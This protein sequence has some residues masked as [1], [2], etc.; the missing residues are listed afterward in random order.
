MRFHHLRMTAFGPFPDEVAIDLDALGESGLFL[1]HGPTGAGKTSILDAI[2]FALFADVP[3]RRPRRG[4]RSDH[5][6]EG[7]APQ[8]V[9]E[10]TAGGTRYRITRSAE[11]VRPKLRGS[12]TTTVPAK[13]TLEQSVAGRWEALSARHDEVAE[14]IH[15][16]LGLGLDQF[17]KVVVLPQGEFAAFLRSSAEDRR[18]LLERLFDISA[19]ADVETWLADRRRTTAVAA[20]RATADLETTLARIDDVLAGTDPGATVGV[21]ATHDTAELS[22]HMSAVLHEARSAVTAT[23][24]AVDEA[25]L[26]E[27]E[28]TAEHAA[29]VRRTEARERAEMALRTLADLA[30]EEPGHLDRTDRVE[31]AVRAAALTGHLAAFHRATTALAVAEEG[32]AETITALRWPGLPHDGGGAGEALA[33]VRAADGAAHDLHT[34]QRRRDEAAER[35]AGYRGQQ[36]SEKVTLAEAAER[37]EA[38]EVTGQA[39]AADLSTALLIP[40]DPQP[41]EAELA[42]LE[43][44][45]EELRSLADDERSCVDLAD[46]A[47]AAQDAALGA[48]AH[49]LDLR[50]AQLAGYAAQLAQGL[51][52]GSPC[53][54]C[55]SAEHPQPATDEALV[56]PEDVEAAQVRADRLAEESRGL[57]LELAAARAT[58]EQRRAALGDLDEAAIAGQRAAAE[59]ALAA[60]RTQQ[61]HIADLR[62]RT[63]RHEAEVAT[64]DTALAQAT[65]A[66]ATVDALVAEAEREEE[67]ANTALGTARDAHASCPCLHH[68]DGAWTLAHH[69]GIAAELESIRGAHEEIDRSSRVLTA[70]R[71]DAAAAATS[72]GFDDLE[73]AARAQ[74]PTDELGE[75]Q[76]LIRD[77][78]DRRRAAQAVLSEP[79]VVAAR[80]VPADDLAALRDRAEAAR[81]AL[82][83]ATRAQSTAEQRLVGLSRLVPRAMSAARTRDEQDGLARRVRD[84]ADTVG[85]LG[86]DNTLRMRLTAFV[87]AARLETVVAFANERLSRLGSGRYRLEHSDERSGGG[88][89]G[90]GL[91]VEDQ[92]TGI[93]REAASLSGGETFMTS[94]ALAL[95]LADAVRAEAGG[96]DLGTLFIDEGF[97]TL[98]DESLE[99]VMD[100]LDGLREGGRSV[101][102]VSHVADLRTRIPNQLVITKTPDG[103]SV[104][105]RTQVG[106]SA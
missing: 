44:R 84:L 81:Q 101:G 88:R 48:R 46:R 102:V 72:A 31:A 39:L 45:D 64:A 5:A 86:S 43:R 50:V 21:S 61:A 105:T 69:E 25:T 7:R 36:A 9:L 53:P 11:Y 3:G 54:V 20:E 38:L 80:E 35:L 57:A 49:H 4:L 99:E 32:L 55:G 34:T 91:T 47:R 104:R 12:G 28:A 66:A 103:S 60:A 23:L 82:L 13:V 15:D 65:V 56:R 16:V 40:H 79:E 30:D 33:A 106:A 87:L 18:A 8:V 52:D 75:L 67:A 94:L 19:Y 74:L 78:E 100:V 41:H 26:A 27:Q 73:A 2:S 95:G 90:L 89:S 29:A 70:T 96:Y 68:V 63:A 85:G 1:I 17:A 37:V 14:R 10:F 62:E 76:R 92:W 93:R 98:D 24:T 22:E 51:T 58:L 6:P 71:L 77:H 97:G 42:L 83:G 59:A